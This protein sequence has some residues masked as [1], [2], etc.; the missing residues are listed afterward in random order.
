[1]MCGTSSAMLEVDSVFRC[2]AI[3]VGSFAILEV[4]LHGHK[5]GSLHHQQHHLYVERAGG[6]GGG[7]GGGV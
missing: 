2:G 1:M 5:V 6:G 7:G 3:V 4:V